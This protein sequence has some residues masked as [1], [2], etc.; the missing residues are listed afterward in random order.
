MIPLTIKIL[1]TNSDVNKNLFDF[2]NQSVSKV[3]SVDHAYDVQFVKPDGKTGYPQMK[4]NNRIYTGVKE[5]SAGVFSYLKDRAENNDLI[6]GDENLLHAVQCDILGVKDGKIIAVDEEDEFEN[7]L[8]K[9]KLDAKEQKYNAAR[10][11]RAINV[12]QPQYKQQLEEPKPKDNVKQPKKQ[13]TKQ[14]AEKRIPTSGGKDIRIERTMDDDVGGTFRAM[15]S[16]DKQGDDLLENM[17]ANMQ[18]TIL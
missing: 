15:K 16:V 10:G 12:E 18:E 6:L 14:T 5:I 8:D 11:S 7:P 9:T 2:L 3:V 17:F 13:A 4:I 1:E